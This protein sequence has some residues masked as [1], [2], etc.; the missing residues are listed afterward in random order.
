MINLKLF[1]YYQIKKN[2]K[3]VNKINI[4]GNDITD[5]FVIR[6]KILFSEGDKFNSSKLNQSINK[7]KN[8]GLFKNVT[9]VNKNISDEKIEIDFAVEEQPTGSIS[10]GAGVG[11]S[12]ATIS[13]GINEKNFLGKGLELNANLNIGTQKNLGNISY[14]NPDFE[15]SGNTFRSTFFVEN[16]QF[17]NASYE[18]KLIGSSV[19]IE[20]E[21]FNKLFFNPGLSFDLDSVSVND[22]AS[23]LIKKREGDYFT[24]KIFYN[25]YKNNLN[26]DFQPTDGYTFGFGQSF[27]IFSDIPFINNKLFG[28]YYNEYIENFV[29]S[30]KYK[31]EAINAFDKDIKFSDRLFVS[32]N[33][34]RGFSSRGIGPKIDNDYIGGNYSFYT[35]L[36]STIPNGLPD[37]WNAIT[38][39]FWDTAYVWCVDDNS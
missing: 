37:N 33:N 30:I 39:I 34:L 25:A 4:I 27:S 8:T 10:A 15:N 14:I 2:Q 18:N 24:S 1:F 28:S 20:Y 16:N 31:L 6:N 26:K 7:L 12:G 38:N 35:N 19:S 29:G 22:D 3:T 5:D 36:S 9:S 23:S 17:D 11:T 32:S 21:V 13:S